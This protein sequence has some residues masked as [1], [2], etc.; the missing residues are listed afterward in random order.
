[1]TFVPFTAALALAAV[2]VS[3]HAATAPS[4]PLGQWTCE[5]FIAVGDQFKPKLIYW[6]TAYSKSGKPEAAVVDVDGT[7]TVTPAIVDACVKSPKASFW[8][9]LQGEWKKLEATTRKDVKKIEKDVQKEV[10]KAE[11]AM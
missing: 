8:Q 10:K 6:A 3:V 2:T 11:K 4:K 9:T 7:E 1:M 5:D